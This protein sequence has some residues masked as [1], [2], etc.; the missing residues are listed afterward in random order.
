MT[1]TEFSTNE[2]GQLLEAG[3]TF[4]D[5]LNQAE[6]EESRFEGEAGRRHHH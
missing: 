3:L 6:P 1:E 2:M 5:L 4:E